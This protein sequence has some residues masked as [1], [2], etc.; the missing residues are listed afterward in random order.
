MGPSQL[1]SW[2]APFPLFLFSLPLSTRDVIFSW[3][4]FDLNRFVPSIL[5]LIFPSFTWGF[6][7]PRVQFYSIISLHATRNTV[8][9][10]QMRG[11]DSDDYSGFSNAF[12]SRTLNP[13]LILNE[14][15]T[16]TFLLL[17]CPKEQNNERRKEWN[18]GGKPHNLDSCWSSLFSPRQHGVLCVEI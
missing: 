5:I 7:F 17:F 10:V 16:L 3:T 1:L 18:G 12:F 13:T 4:T 8:T 2:S 15:I 9:D 14:W 11:E 6:F